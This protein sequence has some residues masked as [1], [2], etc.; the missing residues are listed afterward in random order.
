MAMGLKNAGQIVSKVIDDV[1]F[2]VQEQCASQKDCKNFMPFINKNKP[3]FHIEYVD[4]NG[5]S[6]DRKRALPANYQTFCSGSDV[7][8]PKFST[9]IKNMKLDGWVTYC[10]GSSGTTGIDDA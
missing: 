4:D 10:D 8:I 7:S 1:Q 9:V 5:S 3:V 2:S 6:D